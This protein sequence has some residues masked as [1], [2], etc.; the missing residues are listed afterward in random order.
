MVD[1]KGVI[2]E[3]S[4]LQKRYYCTFLGVFAASVALVTLPVN[5]Y[6]QSLQKLSHDLKSRLRKYC[7]RDMCL[8]TS[9]SHSLGEALSHRCR[10][11][12]SPA[13]SRGS[14]REQL[15]SHHSMHAGWN[16]HGFNSKKPTF[17]AHFREVNP[18]VGSYSLLSLGTTQE[19]HPP[20]C[21]ISSLDTKSLKVA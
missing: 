3:G 9:F 8:M 11:L 4:V 12:L 19:H 18:E 17:R 2:F 15:I 10:S 7:A 13:S 21:D 20:M 5:E 16:F 14:G 1:K 6:I